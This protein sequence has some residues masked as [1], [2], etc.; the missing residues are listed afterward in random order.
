MANLIRKTKAPNQNCP[1]CQATMEPDVITLAPLN[2]EI[3]IML[4]ECPNGC[5]LDW[6]TGYQT[7][8]DSTRTFIYY[9]EDDKDV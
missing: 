2:P 9:E 6:N 5:K 4:Y 8:K 7:I 3:Y 1:H